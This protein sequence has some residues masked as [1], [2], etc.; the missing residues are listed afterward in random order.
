MGGNRN[1]KWQNTGKRETNSRMKRKR[2]ELRYQEIWTSIFWAYEFATYAQIENSYLKRTKENF[3]F[4]TPT[5]SKLQKRQFP[6]KNFPAQHSKN[7]SLNNTPHEIRLREHLICLPRSRSCPTPSLSSGFRSNRL[8]SWKRFI[9]NN[10][11]PY[12]QIRFNKTIPESVSRSVRRSCPNEP[13]CPALGQSRDIW[14][15]ISLNHSGEEDQEICKYNIHDQYQF[16]VPYNHERNDQS[17]SSSC[18][19]RFS[20]YEVPIIRLINGM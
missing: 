2:V 6:P 5:H 20:D 18:T 10:S 17:E 11:V 12:H 7:F 19:R 16:E 3:P 15:D 4:Q 14:S 9:R 13:F 8:P 1:V